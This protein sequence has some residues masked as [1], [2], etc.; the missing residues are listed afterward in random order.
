MAHVPDPEGKTSIG[1]HPMTGTPD[2]EL[3]DAVAIAINEA[4]KNDGDMFSA[5]IAAVLDHYA[6][7]VR[8][9]DRGGADAG[10]F[11]SEES[12]RYEANR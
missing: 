1:G 9:Y 4:V 8:G 7:L 11:L 12:A 3:K 2:D 10:G 5:A 6:P